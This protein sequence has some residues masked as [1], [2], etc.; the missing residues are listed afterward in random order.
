MDRT[1]LY[2]NQNFH[3]TCKYASDETAAVT[4]VDSSNLLDFEVSTR[5]NVLLAFHKII[6]HEIFK[7]SN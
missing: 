5:V 1:D 4:F 2:L 3:T 6:Y 7:V